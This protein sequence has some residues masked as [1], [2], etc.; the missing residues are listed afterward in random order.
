MRASI[1]RRHNLDVERVIAS[2]DVVL[3]A[4]VRKLDVPPVVAGKVALPCPVLDLQ[5]IAIGSAIAAVTIAVVLLQ[6]PLILAFQVVLEDD[7]VDVRA[8]VTEAFGFLRVGA[9]EFRVMLQFAWLRDAG[10]ERL[11]IAGV[12]VQTP[13][14]QQFA[15]LSCQ[16]DDGVVAVEADRLNQP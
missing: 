12:I 9:I 16:R 2:I 5:R 8:F 3:D 10:I 11:A 6:E 13:R 7:A 15:P 14:F 1:V 4:H